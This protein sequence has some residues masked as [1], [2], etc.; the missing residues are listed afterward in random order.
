[1]ES[2]NIINK[3]SQSSG[4]IVVENIKSL[5]DPNQKVNIETASTVNNN[6]KKSNSSRYKSLLKA[7]GDTVKKRKE[8]KENAKFNEGKKIERL[9]SNL[10][11]DKIKPK[12]VDKTKKNVNL[13]LP[14]I[15]LNINR[16]LS[17]IDNQLVTRKTI[18]TKNENE[19]KDIIIIDNNNVIII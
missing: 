3:K 10:G 18:P 6:P 4:K 13:I 2:V 19:E 9:K 8:D 17:T 1:M 5:E 14:N 12:I 11:L 15:N 16:P 7:L